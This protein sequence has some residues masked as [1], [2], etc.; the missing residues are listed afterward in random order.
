MFNKKCFNRFRPFFGEYI[1]GPIVEDVAI[2]ID[3]E[4]RRTVVCMRPTNHLLQ[5]FRVAIHTAR[6]ERSIGT[7][8]QCPRIEWMIETSVRGRLR[9]FMF[10]AG[11]R[12][13]PFGESVNLIVEQQNL[14]IEITAQQVNEVVTTNAHSVAITGYNPHAQLGANCLEAA[15]HGGCTTVNRV[16]PIRIHIIREARRTTN[17]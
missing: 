9:Y 15:C 14:H 4:E 6:Y 10:F 16:H 3:F 17:A 5:M 13:L 12:I 2:L 11:R 8:G 1:E 7:K